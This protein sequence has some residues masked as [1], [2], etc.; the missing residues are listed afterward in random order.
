[1]R[2]AMK[3][4]RF[5]KYE[6]TFNRCAS[7]ALYFPDILCYALFNFNPKVINMSILT[8]QGYTFFYGFAGYY[9][10]KASLGY[11]ANLD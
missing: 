4:H 1:M 5:Q 3:N 2:S 9:Y 10:R 11:P 8:T 7:L 6:Q